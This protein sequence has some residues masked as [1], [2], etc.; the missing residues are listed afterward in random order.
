MA[1]PTRQDAA[2]PGSG[3]WTFAFAH[4]FAGAALVFVFGTWLAEPDAPLSTVIPAQ[5][6]WQAAVEGKSPHGEVVVSGRAE[7]ARGAEPVVAPV[8]R[9]PVLAYSVLVEHVRMH[10]VRRGKMRHMERELLATNLKTSRQSSFVV[11]TDDGEVAIKADVGEWLLP[12]PKAV[13]HERGSRLPAWTRGRPGVF[14]DV[15]W[16]VQDETFYDSE[17]IALRAGDAVTFIGVLREADG[18]RELV[19]P[20]GAKTLVA[21]LRGRTSIDTKIRFAGED[22]R[23]KR[24]MNQLGLAAGLLLLFPWELVIW[25]RRRRAAKAGPLAP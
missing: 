18:R 3:L 11:T 16:Y 4:M 17:E 20:P 25:L 12:V 8:S 1:D 15:P 10:E 13:H 23:N 22:I 2:K 24:R 6:R 14:H 9:K 5:E 19:P 7:P 21:Y